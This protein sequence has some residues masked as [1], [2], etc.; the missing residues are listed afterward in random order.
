M[1]LADVDEALYFLCF[2]LSMEAEQSLYVLCIVG[3]FFLYYLYWTQLNMFETVRYLAVL[4]VPT[5]LF[6]NQLLCTIASRR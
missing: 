6:G 2:T 1:N 5:F 3:I 4:G